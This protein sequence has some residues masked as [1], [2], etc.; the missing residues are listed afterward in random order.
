M[1]RSAREL[2]STLTLETCTAEPFL[3]GRC[4]VFASQY[5]AAL[6]PQLAHQMLTSAVL[7]IEDESHSGSEGDVVIKLSAVR[8]I[9]KFVLPALL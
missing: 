5:A 7:A 6:P 2:A 3:L 4:F 1:S 9:K 8:C